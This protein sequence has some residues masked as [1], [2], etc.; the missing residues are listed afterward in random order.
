MTGKD[1]ESVGNSQSG[2]DSAVYTLTAL[3]L[4]NGES[5]R[6]DTDFQIWELNFSNST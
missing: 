2:A 1:S 4:D 3:R 5:F 6:A